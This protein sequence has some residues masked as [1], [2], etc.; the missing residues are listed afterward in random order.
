LTK[1]GVRKTL[2]SIGAQEDLFSSSQL[3]ACEMRFDVTKWDRAK[4]D[5]IEQEEKSARADLMGD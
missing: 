1:K 2:D 4:F 3:F 5:P